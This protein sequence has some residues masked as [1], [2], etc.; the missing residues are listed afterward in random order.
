MN[1]LFN[2]QVII[3]DNTTLNNFITTN[4]FIIDKLENFKLWLYFDI[5]HKIIIVYLCITLLVYNY[6]V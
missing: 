3:N 6:I 4:N 2:E 5:Y 1:N